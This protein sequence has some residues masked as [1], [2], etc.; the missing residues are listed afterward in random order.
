MADAYTG[1]AASDYDQTAWNLE[2]WYALRPELYGDQLATIG[3][4]PQSM[5]GSAVEF[6]FNNDLAAATTALT[7]TVTPDSVAMGDTTLTVTIAEYGNVVKKTKLLQATSFIPFDPIAANVVGYNAAISLDTLAM[8]ALNGG[9]NVDYSD[10][11]THVTRVTQGS[12]D[13]IT[14]TAVRK[15]RAKLRGAFV[16]PFESGLYAAIIHPD[17]SYD[18]R[19]ATDLASWRAANVYVDTAHIMAGDLG[20]YEQFR[21]LETPRAGD[22]VNAGSGS[23]YDVYQTLFLGQQALAKAYASGD[24]APGPNPIVRPGPIVDPLYRFAPIGWYWLGAYS[25]FR[26]AAVRRLETISSIANNA[27]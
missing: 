2:A 22:L 13:I 21:F 15:E 3:T 1:T 10:V 24:G 8:N 9:T 19:G 17:V 11:S 5:K 4:E 26:Q 12:G 27:S 25:I 20:I 7:E 14:A 18:L 6:V 16:Q 23:T